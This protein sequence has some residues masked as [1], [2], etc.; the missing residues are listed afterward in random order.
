MA[1]L[2]KLIKKSM[3]TRKKSMKTNFHQIKLEYLKQMLRSYCWRSAIYSPMGL[4]VIECR[5]EDT[6]YIVY[7]YPARACANLQLVELSRSSPHG[8]RLPEYVCQTPELRRNQKCSL[9][10]NLITVLYRIR[11]SIVSR[12]ALIHF[13]AASEISNFIYFRLCVY[14]CSRTDIHNIFIT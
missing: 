12:D 4:T 7:L 14:T 8:C 3:Q 13:T 1:N 6:V 10:S 5:S 2:S 11:C 9:K